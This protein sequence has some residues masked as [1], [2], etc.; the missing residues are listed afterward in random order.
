MHTR[1]TV[2]D[3]SFLSLLVLEQFMPVPRFLSGR[4]GIGVR[5]KILLDFLS[6]GFSGETYG[7]WLGMHIAIVLA[8]C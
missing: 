5:G 2:I 6:I 8:Q 1:T 3:S 4:C 7:F